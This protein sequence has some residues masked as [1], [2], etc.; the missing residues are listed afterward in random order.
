MGL[1]QAHIKAIGG[2]RTDEKMNPGLKRTDKQVSSAET[3]WKE[4]RG[5]LRAEEN[6]VGG[7]APPG[8]S[9]ILHS[10]RILGSRLGVV[11]LSHPH[12]LFPTSIIYALQNSRQVCI[13]RL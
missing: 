11:P 2:T 10:A 4:K 7:R 9:R 8:T 13:H 3:A 1:R 12:F 6:S 5:G